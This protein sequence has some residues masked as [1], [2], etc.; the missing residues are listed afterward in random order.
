MRTK[1]A[2]AV[3]AIAAA[4]VWAA[5]RAPA[6]E[7]D[8]KPPDP[9]GQAA[10]APDAEKIGWRIGFQSYTFRGV[11][12]FEALDASA[13]LGLKYI[14]AWP[15]HRMSKEDKTALSRMN[16]QQKQAVKDKLKA[17][18]VQIVNVGVIGI[19]KDE[20]SARKM[21]LWWKDLGA[22]TIVTESNLPFLDKLCEELKMNVAFHNHPR[23]WPPEQ[24]LSATKDRSK[25]IGACAD[26]GHWMRANFVPVETIKKL[27]GRIISLHFKDLNEFGRGHDVI[28][29]TG[30][31][32]AKGQLAELYDQGFKGSFAIEYEHTFTLDDLAKCVAFFNDTAKQLAAAKPMPAPAEP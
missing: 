24:V 9:A 26:T 18:G 10:G 4:V 16:D 7:G 17:A 29:G 11:T 6:A 31:G 27:K 1:A 23:S 3:V 28:W 32:D 12:F 14:E 25:R 15:G 19:P 13:K 22:E 21:F 2:M 30:K 5:G 20:A 8:A